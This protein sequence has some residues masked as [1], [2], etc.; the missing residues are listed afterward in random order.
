[1][2]IT[3]VA[4]SQQRTSGLVSGETRAARNDA[5]HQAWLDHQCSLIPAAVRGTLVLGEPDAGPF[6]PVAMWPPGQGPSP[7][8]AEVSQRTLE[9]RRALAVVGVPSSVVAAPVI[10]DG[11]LHG[12]VA[13]ETSLQNDAALQE[14]LRHLQWGSQGIE[15]S[16]RA[17]QS[18]GEQ[19]T[20]ER[21]IATLDLVASVLSEER[22]APAAQALATDLAIRLDCDR[23]SIGFVRDRHAKVRA[24]SH[25]ADFGERMNLIRAIGTAMDEALDQKS[26][27]VF[28]ARETD[29]LVV[30]DHAALAR[31]FGSDS[32]LTVPFTVGEDTTGAFCFERPGTRPFD[33]DTIELCQAVAALCSRIL[34]AKRLNDRVLPV[35][36]LDATREQL[37]RMFGPRYYGRKV[38]ALLLMAAAVFFSVATGDYRVGAKA[39]LEGSVRRVLVAP[40]DGYV[41]SAPRRAGDVVSAGTVLATLDDRD[42]RL[43]YY[44]WASQRAQYGKQHQEA[45]AQRERAQGGIVQAQAQQAE[46]QMNLL[47]EQLGRT[48]I[49]APFEGLVVS[50]DLSQSL[51]SAVKRG[52]VLFEV[53]PLNAYRVVVEV[54]EGEINNIEEGQKGTLLLTSLPGEVFPFTVKRL[55]PIVASREG[56]SFFRVEADLERTSERLRPGMDGV[57]KVEV[58]TRKLFWIGTH[59]LVDWLHL[60]LWSWL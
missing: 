12:L 32:I 54:D 18:T 9:E 25:S 8:L 27:V 56:R 48:R 60:T 37:V 14:A 26:I 23:V 5:H 2:P 21:L 28:P 11:Q 46:A 17:E 45:V 47:A 40:F 24:V 13:V 43:E 33:A 39:S 10:M 35:R 19:T 3:A 34:E 36:M 16:L 20:R 7:M 38:A 50:G 41:A 57:A 51:G 44:K 58:G 42:L 31:Q 49:T 4:E 30:R 1:V 59:K 29:A 55:T 53:S 52:Q 22:F 6:V 15:A